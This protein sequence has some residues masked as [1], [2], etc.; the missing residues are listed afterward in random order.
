MQRVSWIGMWIQAGGIVNASANVRGIEIEIGMRGMATAIGPGIGIMISAI[1]VG[2]GGLG[3]GSDSVVFFIFSLFFSLCPWASPLC[4]LTWCS[5]DVGT[6]HSD[7]F[8]SVRLYLYRLCFYSWLH[9][10]VSYRL[11][12]YV[13][14]YCCYEKVPRS[15]HKFY[16]LKSSRLQNW[17]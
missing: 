6:S 4:L 12:K 8:V 14:C 11:A 15:T 13:I 9:R 10:V 16:H 3:G 5:V 17:E 1:I 2:R 7:F